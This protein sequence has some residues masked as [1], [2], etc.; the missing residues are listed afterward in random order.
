MTRDEDIY[1]PQQ[2]NNSYTSF[3]HQINSRAWKVQGETIAIRNISVVQV[4]ALI[5][6]VENILFFLLAY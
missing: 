2:W 1:I 3:V 5:I 4:P 6:E